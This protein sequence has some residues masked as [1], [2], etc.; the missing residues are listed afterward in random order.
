L[1]TIADKTIIRIIEKCARTQ[2]I[3]AWTPIIVKEVGDRF[4]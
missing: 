1:G 2:F 3:V 4:H